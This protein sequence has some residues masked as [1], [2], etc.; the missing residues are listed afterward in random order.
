MSSSQINLVGESAY[1]STG[2]RHQAEQRVWVGTHRLRLRF[3]ILCLF[4]TAF[5]GPVHIVRAGN[6]NPPAVGIFTNLPGLPIEN[7]L[8]SKGWQTL[9]LNWGAAFD[10]ASFR[11]FNVIV[12]S[13]YPAIDPD[14]PR[15]SNLGMRPDYEQHV[16]KLLA[17]YVEAGGGLLV[18]GGDSPIAAKPVNLL[19]ANFGAELLNETVVDS[20]HTF[21]QQTGMQFRYQVTSEIAKHPATADVHTLFYPTRSIYGAAVNPLRLDR[22]WDLLIRGSP[23]AKSHPLI[24]QEHITVADDARPGA[25]SAAPP[26]AAVRS[27]GQ[28]RVAVFGWSPIQT[29]FDYGHYMVEDIYFTRGGDGVPSDGLRLLEQTLSYIADPSRRD[30][31]AGFGGYINQPDRK[32]PQI[33][34]PIVWKASTVGEE[35]PGARWFK[36]IIGART[37]LTGGSGTVA[38]YAA[39]ARA[40]KLDFIAFMEDFSRLTEAKWEKFRTECRAASGPDLLVLPGQAVQRGE[41]GDRYFKISDYGWPQR[42]MLTADGTRIENYLYEHFQSGLNTLGPFDLRHEPSPFWISRAYNSMAVT[43]TRDGQTSWELDPFLYMTGLSDSPK[44]IAID[45]I[46]SPREVPDAARRI[47]NLRLCTSQEELRHSL[48]NP[49]AGRPAQI[50]NGPIITTWQGNNLARMTWGRMVAGSERFQL[51]LKAG[52][53][54]PLTEAIVYDGANVFRRYRFTNAKTCDLLI[55]GL[56]DRQHEFTVVV[57]DASGRVALRSGLNTTDLMYRRFMCS[58]RQNSLG[59]GYLIDGEGYEVVTA[60]GFEQGKLMSR[61]GGFPANPQTVGRVPWYWDG[62]P[63]GY[64]QGG[65]ENSMWLPPLVTPQPKET[66]PALVSRMSFPLG[67]RDV[68]CQEINTEAI[69]PDHPF[70]EGGFWPIKPL[71]RYR[72]QTR[73]FEFRKTPDGPAAMLIE[74]TYTMLEDGKWEPHEWYWSRFSQIFYSLGGSTNASC[75]WGFVNPDGEALFGP[76]PPRDRPANFVKLLQPGGYLAYTT[77]HESGAIFPLD[78]PLQFAQELHQDNWFR[79]WLGYNRLGQTY[80]KGQAIPYRLV[81]FTG[82]RNAPPDNREIESFRQALGLSSGPPAYTVTPRIGNVRSTRYVLELDAADGGFDGTISKAPLPILL[83]IRV[84]GVNPNWTCAIVEHHDKWWLPVGV[85]DG[86]AYATL[87]TTSVHDVWIGNV[88]TCEQP[89]L[90]LTLL[91]DGASGLAIEIHNPTDRE[92]SATVRTAPQFTLAPFFSTR[93]TIPTGASELIEAVENAAR[94]QVNTRER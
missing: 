60:A 81:V 86:T 75:S 22:Q 27:V 93:V 47:L 6:A 26:I 35:A 74:G 21:S 38:E 12:L 42:D 37:A 79:L 68:I 19:L 91:P 28:G 77:L 20:V 45:L 4:S 63:G 73:C 32:R 67:S 15:N 40:A 58:D 70:H 55:D 51:R 10:A 87:D 48:K 46:N 5:F 88:V 76:A 53:D 56:H 57:R 29:F 64:V 25:F 49:D 83:P 31:G 7:Y 13:E 33:P 17:E 61:A 52:S 89:D 8:R 23:E 82:S 84:H 2:G 16:R 54:V 90:I 39:A 71:P 3:L 11:R 92:I 18:Y 69:M 14:A 94:R 50:S 66:A 24:A 41:A 72:A 80:R 62:A 78:E 44:P 1:S 36:G 85:L 43:T 30:A 59:N 65:V 34:K 9:C